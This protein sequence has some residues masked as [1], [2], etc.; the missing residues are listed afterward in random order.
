MSYLRHISTRRLL[1][2]VSAARW[3]SARRQRGGD[4]PGRRRVG[5]DAA[6]Q[7]ARAGRPR[8]ARRPAGRGRHGPDRLHE[9]PRRRGEPPGQP[10]RCSPAPRGASGPPA[11]SCASS[12]RP[13]A[14]TAAPAT[15]RCCSTATGCRS[16]TPARTPSTGSRCRRTRHAERAAGER[17]GAVARPH[18]GRADAPR[19]RTA[20]LSG[21]QPEQRRRPAR[22]HRARSRRATTAGCSAAPR[23]AWDAEHGVPLRAAVYASGNGD[24]VLELRGDRHLVRPGGR[25]RPRRCPSPRARRSST[26]ARRPA[27]RA[28]RREGG[29]PVTGLDAVQAKVPFKIVAPD[30]LVG[31]PRQ[32]VRLVDLDG[33]PGRA[34]DLRPGPRRHRRPRR[35]PPRRSRRPSAGRP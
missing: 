2:L 13:R 29:Q 34:R 21:A 1:A 17:A 14:P 8:R 23:L 35:A 12:C 3:R 6:A 28:R 25:R 24:P 27:A 5:A 4:R 26:S 19:P 7:A 20:T 11:T 31:L 16:S 32:E 10:T 18:P 15:C 30:T 33:T 9:P 22:L